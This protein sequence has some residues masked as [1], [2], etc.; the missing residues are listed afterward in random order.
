MLPTQQ[1]GLAVALQKYIAH[2]GEDLQVELDLHHYVKQPPA[3]EEALYRIAQEALNNIVKHA[4]AQHV[5]I[6]LVTDDA[7]TRLTVADDGVGFSGSAADPADVG[8]G[9]RAG[10]GGSRPAAAQAGGFGLV[11][12]RERAEALGGRLRLTAKPGQGT[13]VLVELPGK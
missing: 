6:R 11:T 3:T 12:M 13:T 7:T 9:V 10:A 5:E 2:I 8:T 4:C 1:D